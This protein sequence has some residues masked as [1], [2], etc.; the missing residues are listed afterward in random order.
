[1]EK[2]N[3]NVQDI[4]IYKDEKKG[5]YTILVLLLIS[6]G[7]TGSYYFWGDKYAMLSLIGWITIGLIGL[8]LWRILEGLMDRTKKEVLENG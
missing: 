5:I 1:M 3:K 6:W 4:L 2:L 7:M 8:S